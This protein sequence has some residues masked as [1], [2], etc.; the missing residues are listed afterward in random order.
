[1]DD[2]KIKTVGIVDIELSGDQYHYFLVQS[3]DETAIVVE[4]SKDFEVSNQNY[5]IR[6]SLPVLDWIF[7]AQAL[8]IESQDNQD[9]TWHLKLAYTFSDPQDQ[10]KMQEFFE[11][12]ERG[13]TQIR[14]IDI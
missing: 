5:T 10:A 8:V 14:D 2:L 7:E 12:Y 11:M 9:Q 4:S 6:F 1:M 3:L 13:E